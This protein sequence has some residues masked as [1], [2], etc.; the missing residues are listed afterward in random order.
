MTP[1]AKPDPETLEKFRAHGGILSRVRERGSAMTIG[2]EAWL[3]GFDA[4][5]QY[6]QQRDEWKL[7]YEQ[8]HRALLERLNTTGA[9]E[10]EKTAKIARYERQRE[11]LRALCER[12]KVCGEASCQCIVVDRDEV[13]RTMQFDM[14][15]KGER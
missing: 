15:A 10:L 1:A 12:G 4:L 3:A 8:E 14:P 13:Y 11:E 2:D 9:N 7:K 5:A 6:E